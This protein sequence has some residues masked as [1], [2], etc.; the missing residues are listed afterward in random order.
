MQ[1]TNERK[2]MAKGGGGRGERDGGRGLKMP[3]DFMPSP[4]KCGHF[5]CYFSSATNLL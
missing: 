3:R 2:R 5:Q 1:Y 4:S